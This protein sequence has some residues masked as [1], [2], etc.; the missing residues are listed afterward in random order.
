MSKKGAAIGTIV[1]LAI[2]AIAAVAII[3]NDGQGLALTG[4]GVAKDVKQTCDKQCEANFKVC[5]QTKKDCKESCKDVIA[6]TSYI[7]KST[8]CGDNAKAS[9]PRLT[10]ASGWDA[11]TC[12]FLGC[13]WC[14][15]AND[16]SAKHDCEKLCE[17][18]H[19]ACEQT[20]KDCKENCKAP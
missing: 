15:G 18:D 3:D 5:E 17:D 1:L 9:C 8:P 19:K 12:E 2:F 13:Y 6:D 10:P 20:K 14:G 4:A 16:N 7:C 11:T